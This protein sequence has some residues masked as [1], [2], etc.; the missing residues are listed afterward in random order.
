[1]AQAAAKELA[2]LAFFLLLAPGV[3]AQTPAAHIVAIDPGHGGP[4]PGAV[5]GDLVERD[6]NLAIGLDLAQQLTDEG[7]Q[8]V[9]TRTS[10][11]A[12]NPDYVMAPDRPNARKDLQMRVDTANEA[13]ADLFLSLHNNS[14]VNPAERG[15]EVW[16]DGSRPFAEQNAALAQLVLDSVVAEVN[17]AGYTDVSRGTREDSRYRVFGERAFP[18]FV[19]G[20]GTSG[21]R[22]YT[23]TGMPGVLGETL[24]LSNP[25]DAH[26]LRQPA[27]LHAIASGYRQAVQAYFQDQ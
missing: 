8:V 12:V 20:P 3:H 19:L 6:L 18:L 14:S 7:F 10:S 21:F 9:L 13:N 1:M 4:E 11:A 25:G 15:T 17:R 5:Y 16:Y 24:F 27:V 2:A 23:P 22:Q 26:A